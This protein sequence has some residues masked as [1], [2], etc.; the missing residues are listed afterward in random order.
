M[1]EGGGRKNGRNV[2][3]SA[4]NTDTFFIFHRGIAVGRSVEISTTGKRPYAHYAL[5]TLRTSVAICTP[6]YTSYV[7]Q[8]D[9]FDYCRLY[10][11]RHV[12]G[13][14]SNINYAN[15]ALRRGSVILTFVRLT[16]HEI[17]RLYAR[18]Q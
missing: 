5:I 10:P 14:I 18:R 1:G 6:C 17:D 9:R 8:A 7:P 15:C 11:T 3:H 4:K 16:R 2:Y 13:C 12:A